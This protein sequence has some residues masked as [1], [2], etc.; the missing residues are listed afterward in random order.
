[1]GGSSPNCGVASHWAAMFPTGSQTFNNPSSET[2]ISAKWAVSLTFWITLLI[3]ALMYS[4][5]TLAPRLFAWIEN[6]HSFITNAHQLQ[7][8]ETEVDYLE[9]V[10]D[11]LESDPDFVRRMA[12]A[13]IAEDI[14]EAEIIPVSGTLI[15]GNKDQLQERMPEIEAPVGTDLVQRFASDR[16]LRSGLLL[17]AGLLVAFA[18]SVLNGTG[19][20]FVSGVNRLAGAVVRIPVTRYRRI[21]PPQHSAED[22]MPVPP[23]VL[24]SLDSTADHDDRTDSDH[25]VCDG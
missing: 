15:F 21:D 7:M 18:F 17:T 9:R 12:T 5:V 6:R 20:R 10:R 13:S 16:Q 11:A 23:A 24:L 3:A 2:P 8:L 4:S 1:M 14:G 25:P 22:E 19:G